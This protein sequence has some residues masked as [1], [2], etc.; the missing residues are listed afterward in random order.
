M[1]PRAGPTRG[2]HR[3]EPLPRPQDGRGTGV[4]DGQS[5]LEIALE[6]NW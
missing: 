3:P 6:S 4:H 1:M 5:A 2:R